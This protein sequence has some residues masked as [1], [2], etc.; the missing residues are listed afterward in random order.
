MHGPADSSG[1]FSPLRLCAN[2]FIAFVGAGVLGL[3]YAFR[4]AGVVVGALV[5]IFVAAV[6][7]ERRK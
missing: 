7:C 4:E 6:W 5:M 2:I 1:P 3:P